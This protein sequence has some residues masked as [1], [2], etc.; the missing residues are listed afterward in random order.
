MQKANLSRND[1]ES[2]ADPKNVDRSFTGFGMVFRQPAGSGMTENLREILYPSWEI[3]PT[4]S[5]PALET[6]RG[7]VSTRPLDAVHLRD[8][9]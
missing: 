2:N 1:G 3:L 9:V 6:R 4:H 7:P 5:T 8:T